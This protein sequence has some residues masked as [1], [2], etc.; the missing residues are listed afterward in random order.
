MWVRRRTCLWLKVGLLLCQYFLWPAQAHLVIDPLRLMEKK[1]QRHLS[2]VRNVPKHRKKKFALSNPHI[3][4]VKKLQT[5]HPQWLVAYCMAASFFPTATLRFYSIWSF[6]HFFLFSAQFIWLSVLRWSPQPLRNTEHLGPSL[7]SSSSSPKAVHY[8]KTCLHSPLSEN[9]F[10][11]PRPNHEG[12]SLE[13]CMQRALLFI[14]RWKVSH[15]V[16]EETCE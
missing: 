16:R 1:T 11:L 7:P 5:E 14:H 6:A 9:I 15:F 2:Q 8:V 4:V 13:R 10:P 12:L 3:N